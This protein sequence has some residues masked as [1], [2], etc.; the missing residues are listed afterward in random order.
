MNSHRSLGA[1]ERGVMNTLLIP[2]ILTVVMLLAVIGFGAWAYMGRQDYKNNV[3]A[4]IKTATEIAVQEAKTAKD[5]EFIEKEKLPLK[6]YQGSAQ[7]GS[8]IVKYPKTWS[9]YVADSN[10]G[11]TPIDGYFYPNTVPGTASDAAYALRVQVINKTFADE[12]KSY[13]SLVKQG[14][15]TAQ[16]YQ[17]VNVSGVVGLRVEGEISN[18]KQGI[19]VLV[20]LRDK[21]IKIYTESNQ[22]FNDFNNNVLPNFSFTP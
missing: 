1:D 7:A 14:K 2:L 11:N 21:T 4:K 3:D 17:P 8:L 19:M 22:Y 18:K 5:N 6:S 10:S 12:I 16:P 13:D 20:P 15:A 9:G